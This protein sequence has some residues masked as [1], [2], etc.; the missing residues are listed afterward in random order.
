MNAGLKSELVSWGH[1]TWRGHR[2]LALGIAVLA[3]LCAGLFGY[4]AT[5]TREST[6]MPG[7][8]Y[9]N[10]EAR[11]AAV[12]R[13][14]QRSTTN[15]LIAGFA[16][17]IAGAGVASFFYLKGHRH[18]AVRAINDRPDRIVWIEHT[19]VKNRPFDYVRVR[20]DD[21]SLAGRLIVTRS[22]AEAFVDKLAQ[23]VPHASVGSSIEQMQKYAQNPSS[24]R[25]Q[26]G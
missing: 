20:L 4:G 23:A 13:D 8:Q 6:A 24:L 16:L 2:T 1:S 22:L 7:V 11:Q 10:E 19:H 21:G 3:L 26:Q 18:P 5:Q 17:L 14:A 15:L 12:G 9:A 25:R